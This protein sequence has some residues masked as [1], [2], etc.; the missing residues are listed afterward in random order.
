M[1][2]VIDSALDDLAKSVVDA[3]FK[4]HKTLGSGLLE[5]AYE[6]C[7]GIELRKRGIFFPD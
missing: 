3:A 5:S 6:I 4:V 2:Q 7:L 1:H